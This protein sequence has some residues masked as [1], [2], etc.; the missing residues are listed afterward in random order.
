MQQKTQDFHIDAVVETSN[1][2]HG[3][4]CHSVMPM[5]LSFWPGIETYA[6]PVHYR[7]SNSRKHS[8]RTITCFH[9]CK[10]LNV[11]FVGW[12]NGLLDIFS[13]SGPHMR[14]ISK[15]NS[16]VVSIVCLR[17]Q[18]CCIV[19]AGSENGY[20]DTWI[21]D[22]YTHK[23][24][25]RTRVCPNQRYAIILAY[26]DHVNVHKVDHAVKTVVRR[27]IV[28]LYSKRHG[29]R[30]D[31]YMDAFKRTIRRRSGN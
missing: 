16:P 22:R 29:C 2:G 31:S 13:V 17:V 5:T 26:Y 18:K 23:H 7:L 3:I 6:Y 20:F 15:H 14:T 11:V 10:N 21:I 24:I 28:E 27:T 9:Y 1:N 30:R 12:S 8:D 25:Q 19:V 4:V